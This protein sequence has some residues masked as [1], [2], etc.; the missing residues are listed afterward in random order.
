MQ[1]TGSGALPV[2]Q[3]I[4]QPAPPPAG[5]GF[6]AV[7]TSTNTPSLHVGPSARIS[8]TPTLRHTQ[9]TRSC[10][11]KE[12]LC[13]PLIA[14]H[15]LAANL[16]V[17]L[18]RSMHACIHAVLTVTPSSWHVPPANMGQQHLGGKRTC[19]VLCDVNAKRIQPS[20]GDASCGQPWAR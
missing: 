3:P 20:H 1:R 2:S 8:R 4:K 9:G 7:N 11:H 6:I 18:H 5:A 16:N 13:L 15:R 19:I 17:A 10:C 14:S 12:N